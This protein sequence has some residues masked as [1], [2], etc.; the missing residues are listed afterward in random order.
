M[1]PRGPGGGGINDL[2]KIK[3]S[4]GR[5]KAVSRKPGKTYLQPKSTGKI[6]S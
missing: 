2:F 1:I 5:E 6:T 4:N 3:V